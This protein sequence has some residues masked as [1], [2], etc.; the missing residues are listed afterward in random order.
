MRV[1]KRPNLGGH[2]LVL[3]F[4]KREIATL[5]RAE[6]IAEQAREIADRYENGGEG[7]PLDD[8]LGRAEHGPGNLADWIEQNNGLHLAYVEYHYDPV[9]AARVRND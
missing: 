4:S 7:S 8:D 9:F 5:R 6:A 1:V 2:S 3:K